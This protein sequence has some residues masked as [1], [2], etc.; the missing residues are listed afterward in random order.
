MVGARVQVVGRVT[1][2]NRSLMR[3]LG[4]D[5]SGINTR[6]SLAGVTATGTITTGV[7]ENSDPVCPASCAARSRATVLSLSWAKA[8]V[9]KIKTRNSSV[10]KCLVMGEGSPAAGG[11]Q[12]GWRRAAVNWG[13][14]GRLRP[15][16]RES[17]KGLGKKS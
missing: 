11:C 14:G 4:L 17:V 16:L 8:E 7:A 1:G 3:M 5:V 13:G 9:K 6:G 2:T 10:G 12:Q 15:A